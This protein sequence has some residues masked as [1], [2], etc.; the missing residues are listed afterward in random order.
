[1][2]T[3]RLKFQKPSHLLFLVLLTV[4]FFTSNANAQTSLGYRQKNL[5]CHNCT[6]PSHSDFLLDPWGIAFLPG[7]NFLITENNPGRI[8]IYNVNGVPGI[9]FTLP[10]PAGSTAASSRPT[11]I[12]ADPGDNFPLGP[13]HFQFF[14]ATEEGT[15]V[16]FS[17]DDT[18]QPVNVRVVV[19]RFPASAVYTGITI[20]HPNCCNP[21]LAVTN[22]HD[23]TIEIYGLSQVDLPGH[24]TDPNLPAGYSPYNIQTIGDQV[25]VTYAKQDQTRSTAVFGDGL[26]IVSI[27]DQEGNFV[28]RFA[29]DG[30]KL[31]APWGITKAS[32]NFGPFASDILIGNA[33]DARIGVYNPTTGEFLGPMHDGEGKLISNNGLRALAFRNDGVGDPA[34]LYFVAA[35]ADDFESGLFATVSVGRLTV[36]DLF[37]T[38]ALIGIETNLLATVHPVAGGDVPTG[39]V[40]FYEN[41]VPIGSVGLDAGSANLT[42]AYTVVGT[43]II[44]AEYQG[45]DNLLPSFD[46]RQINV[47][48]PTTI[49]TLAAQ[50]TSASLGDPVTFTATT[51][52]TGAIPAGTVLFKEGDVVLGTAPLNAN[53]IATLTLRNL[54]SGVHSVFASYHSDGRFQE[55]SS[56]PLAV[57]IGGDFQFTPGTPSITVA[58]G[59]STDVTL[60]INPS[61]GFTGAVLFNCLA[62]AGIT[63]SFAPTTLNVNGNPVTTKLTVGA[64][65]ALASNQHGLNFIFA[66][67]GA[68]GTL[69]VGNRARKAKTVLIILAVLSLGMLLVACGGSYGKTGSGTPPRIVTITLSATGGS[70]SHSTSIA[71]TVQ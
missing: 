61:D 24:W 64:S 9:G 69:L 38:D 7:Q 14:A 49:T 55:S 29:S 37:A 34:N 65:A 71:V 40:V 57:T 17:L 66:S 27:F 16:G 2:E 26:G 31:N 18:G 50:P 22:F 70:I 10:L 63:C 11:G 25:F 12:V 19:D 30:L 6:A 20:L 39:R 46:Q 3:S 1:M 60:T 52:A 44:T 59:H 32:A 62:P 43:P 4:C 35:P 53:G 8:D 36:T 45:S 54:R 68:L 47:S 33:G 5:T 58:K 51:Q 67:V 15:I 13:I 21:K 23:G 28:R 48:G 41:G 42:H 56:V